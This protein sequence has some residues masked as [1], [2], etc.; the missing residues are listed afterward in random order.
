[1][2]W[3]EFKDKKRG[4]DFL[5]TPSLD[6][7]LDEDIIEK[8]VFLDDVQVEEDSYKAC[9]VYLLNNLAYAYMELR[10]YSEAIECLNESL[11]V[12]EDKVPDI[13]FRRSQARTCNKFSDESEY[14]K[15]LEDIEKAISLKDDPIYHEHKVLLEK[16]I[17]E[18]LDSELEKTQSKDYF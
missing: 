13:Y 14:Q 5:K 8:H 15:A 11:I 10:H 2:K 7:I 4:D 16:R 6:P 3:I 1:M 9:L 12:A 18:K 17:A